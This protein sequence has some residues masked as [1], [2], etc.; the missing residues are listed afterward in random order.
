MEISPFLLSLLLGW[1]FVWGVILGVL[2]D[3]NR[4]IRVFC[5]EVYSKKHFGKLCS[6]HIR[7]NAPLNRGNSSPGNAYRLPCPQ[8]YNQRH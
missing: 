5:G 1:S 4:I 6:V 3:V 7:G 2:N 8:A